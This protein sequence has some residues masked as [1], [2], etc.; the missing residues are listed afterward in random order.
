MIVLDA[1]T[2]ILLAKAD[3]LE[4]FAAA[5]GQDLVMPKEVEEECCGGKE[6]WDAQVIRDMVGKKRITVRQLR[7]QRVA[8][9]LR[10]DFA[11]GRGEAAA[12]ALAL[13]QGGKAVVVATDDRRAINACKL[14]KLPFTTA[15]AVLV[16]M[17]EK[18]LL[19]S[20][21]ALSKLEVLG[22]FGRYKR[23]TLAAARAQLEGK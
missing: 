13:T 2:A 1:S 15:L 5:A 4:S 23:Q 16:R 14:L 10:A 20:E 12:I 8:A 19:N 3:L 11:L 21:E 6:T 17:R 22:Q 18:G 7:E 9:K